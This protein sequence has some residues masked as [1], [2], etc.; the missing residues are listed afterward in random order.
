MQSLA[1]THDETTAWGGPVAALSSLS[2]ALS[3]PAENHA[4]SSSL[5]VAAVAVYMGCIAAV[6]LTATSLV[7]L[8]SEPQVFSQDQKMLSVADVLEGEWAN[9]TW[10]VFPV[11]RHGRCSCF[12]CLHY[13]TGAI[14]ATS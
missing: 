7:N 3:S 11:F 10:I 2:R 13:L 6:H 14:F 8:K 12:L 1:A 5:G 9:I 4:L